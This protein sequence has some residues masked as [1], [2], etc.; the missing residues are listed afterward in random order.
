MTPTKLADLLEGLDVVL[1]G[2]G[3]VEI[4]GLATCREAGPGDLTLLSDAK[5]VAKLTEREFAAVVTNAEL[6]EKLEDC[7]RPLAVTDDPKG[8]FTTLAARLRPQRPRREIGVSKAA[9]MHPTAVIGPDTNIH[10]RATV[11]PHVTIGRGCEIYPGVVV[12]AGCVIGDGVVLHPGVVLYEDV[13][14]GD[15][16]VVHANAVLGADGFGYELKEGRHERLPHFGTVRIEA[17]V[18]IGAGTTVDR[19]MFGE[20]VIGEGTKIDNLVM[21]AHNDRIGRH[22]ILVGQCGLAGSVTTGDYAVIAGHSGIADHV[23]LGAQSVVASMSGVHRDVP[24][25]EVWGGTPAIPM[26][27]MKKVI[28]NWK[29]AGETRAEVKR[30]TR[31]VAELKAELAA[32]KST[33]DDGPADPR[34]AA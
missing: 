10:P 24:A 5:L 11:G 4:T 12:G 15:R 18:E 1:S 14:L 16:V 22:N 25:G 13:T 33:E 3:D 26:D 2:P 21:I 17:D 19:A 32:A 23:T 9:E 30:L 34:V 8:L 27:E 7:G 29:K 28:F 6:A 31:E 20:T